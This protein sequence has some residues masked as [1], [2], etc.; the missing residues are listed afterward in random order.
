MKLLIDSLSF[1]FTRRFAW[2]MGVFV[3]VLGVVAPAIIM[4]FHKEKVVQQRAYFYGMENGRLISAISSKRKSTIQKL[5]LYHVSDSVNNFI[6]IPKS[7]RRDTIRV[8]PAS[9]VE[10][11]SYSQDSSIVF[12]KI[13][14]PRSIYHGYKAIPEYYEVFIPVLY[15]KESPPRN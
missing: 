9:E 6:K 1:R 10:I 11:F 12:A 7:L 4:S 13:P 15:L 14:N 3:I 8:L 5:L 2:T